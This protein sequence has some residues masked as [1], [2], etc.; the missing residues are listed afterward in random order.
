MKKFLEIISKGIFL[1][2][3]LLISAYFGIY[4]IA[5]NNAFEQ[6]IL[7]ISDINVFS[8]QII[9]SCIMG[10]VIWLF[11]EYCKNILLV[12]AK[13]NEKEEDMKKSIKN[14]LAYSFCGCI[15]FGVLTICMDIIMISSKEIIGKMFVIN[16]VIV[17]VFYLMIIGII[18]VID[19]L[20]INKKIKEKNNE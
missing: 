11:I 18:G 4:F 19:E 2:L 1:G 20:V 10:I 17:A 6:E 7:K 16:F 8:K 9:T 14:A 12:K 5:G 15:A 3:I 13:E